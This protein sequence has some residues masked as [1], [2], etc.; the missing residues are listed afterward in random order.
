MDDAWL[1]AAIGTLKSNPGFYKSMVKGKGAMFGG[2]T[3]EQIES[4]V[5]TAAMMDAGTL[6]WIFK[7]IKYLGSWAKPLSDMYEYLDKKTFG[8]AKHILLCLLAIIIYNV[9]LLWIAVGRYLL[10]Y[11]FGWKAAAATVASAGDALS[12]A[13]KILAEAGSASAVAG[14]VQEAVS[15]TAAAALTAKATP[16]DISNAKQPKKGAVFKE[17]AADMEFSF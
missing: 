15:V 5:D 14:G 16:T 3:D 4:F 13:A 1:N 12:P 2:V 8:F 17:E 6:R 9:V 11:F 7:A 10:S